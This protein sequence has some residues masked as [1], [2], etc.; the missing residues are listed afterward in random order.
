M[1]EEAHSL[2]VLIDFENLALGIERPSGTTPS[3]R[4]SRAKASNGTF[5]VKLVLERLVEKGKV[6]P[7]R[8]APRPW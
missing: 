7:R 2:A 5:D 3:G 4:R 8:R 1:A 6:I